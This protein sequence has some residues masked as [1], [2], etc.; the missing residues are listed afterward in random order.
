MSNSQAIAAVTSCLQQLIEKAFDVPVTVTTKPLD[1]AHIDTSPKRLNLF[2]YSI[3]PNG[4]W[5]NRDLPTERPGERGRPPLALNLQ[6]LLTA[7][8]DDEVESHKL[9]G[10][11]VGALSDHPILLPS[12]LSTPPGVSSAPNALFERVHVTLQPMT[13]EELS[14]LWGAFQSQYRL[15]VAYE[16]S[17]ALIESQHETRASLP[18]LSLGTDGRGPVAGATLSPF[19]LLE[20][21]TPDAPRASEMVTIVGRNLVPSGSAAGNIQIVLSRLG[22]EVRRIANMT[23]VPRGD[24]PLGLDTITFT[25]PADAPPLEA[26]VYAVSALVTTDDQLGTQRTYASNEVLMSIAPRIA[27]M[28]PGKVK[29]G[30]KSAFKVVCDPRPGVTQRVRLLIGLREFKPTPGAGT[31]LTFA[32]ENLTAGEHVVRLRVDGVDSLRVVHRDSVVEFEKPDI[33]TVTP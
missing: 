9:I 8:A 27:K 2:L 33:L 14:K 29:A 24:L 19:P 6:Y 22:E 20:R 4:A 18:V 21:V 31:E 15:S 1:K 16:A 10:T 28:T 11:A 32:A 5:R 17:A 13:I 7:Y 12:E 3:G 30:A 23:I 26:G 25:V